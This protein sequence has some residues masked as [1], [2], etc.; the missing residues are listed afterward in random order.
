MNMKYLFNNLLWLAALML[1][2]PA[3]AAQT[4]N[5]TL[6][7]EV[8]TAVEDN[9]EGQ[10]VTL[11]QTDYSVGYGTLKLDREGRCTVKVYPGN[12]RL[13]V[14]R[15][16]YDTAVKDFAVADGETATVTMVLGEK[17]VTPFALK[18][19]VSHDIYTGRDDALLTWNQEA[20]VFTDDFDSYDPWAVNFGA[21]TGIDA[22]GEATAA[23][24]GSYPNRGIMSYAQ[25]V[26]PLT[27][28]PT[29]WY[30][31][32]VLHPYSG[33]QYVGF[34]RTESGRANDDWLIS[35]AITPGTDNV[36]EFMA[37]A[38]DRYT[39][40]F[41]VYVTTVTDNPSTDDF[42]RLDPGNFET[43]D[44]SGW[45]LCSYSLA[46]YAGKEIKFAIRYVSDA[47]RY[48]AFML[49]VDDVY[50]GQARTD[51][52]STMQRAR[53]A[54]RS[55][56]NP[57]EN[58]NLYLDGV[59]AGTTGSYDF[60]FTGIA[61]GHHTLG[62]EATYQQAVSPRTE[63]EID[64]PEGP[65]ARVTFNVEAL[66]KLTA[67]RVEIGLLN[68][69][70]G[71]QETVVTESG[72]R[73]LLSLPYGRYS[74]YVEE[75]VYEAFS[76]ELE[77]SGDAEVDITLSDKIVDPYNLTADFDSETGDVTLRWNRELGFTDSF[78]EYEDFATSS[79]GDWIT[80]D[81]DQA[82]VYPIALGSQTN[83]VTFPGSGT[84]S[85]PTAIA[86]MVFNPWNTVPAMLPTD[87][88]IAA[89]DGD[90]SVIFFS[91]QRT[92]A[93]KWLISPVLEIR[94][95][96]TLTFKAKGYSSMYPESL[97]ICVS[98][99]GSATPA[100]FAAQAVIEQLTSE[101]WGEYTMDLSEWAG[102]SIRIG[103]H[104]VSTDAFLAQVDQFSVGNADGE[105]DFTDPGNV[106]GY[107]IYIDGV[108]AGESAEPRYV[109]TGL[110]PGTHTAGVRTLYLH[111][112]S[113][114]T[115]CTF[116]VEAGI[117]S[118]GA[119]SDDAAPAEIYDLSGRRL[120]GCDAP[121]IY[122]IRRNGQ[123]LKIK[124]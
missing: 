49:M 63:V 118:V 39:E 101:T 26:N 30:D 25:I 43:A 35:P 33:K 59:K 18:A 2:V 87:Q 73:T 85:N 48:G 3:V 51:G 53:R 71:R 96:F 4:R 92:T 28:V 37:K 31:Y 45:K 22:D 102:Q 5:A 61:P 82:P 122:I 78:E 46:D 55:P 114:M 121:G 29:W 60:T 99:D 41:M 21:W 36:L 27:V 13:T 58:F 62:V 110:E 15:A 88:A 1:C 8:T 109:A 120:S 124:K 91:P 44:A 23:L 67:D 66:S 17:T 12:H 19:T 69:D 47:S 111:G 65:Y 40:R 64:V 98:A 56:A 79:F 113:A 54:L 34:I 119:D 50:V 93:N 10:E 116:G 72:T 32:P 16:G 108:K 115:E 24:Q 20:P 105:G 104:Y 80:A 11:E 95:G 76:R 123:T 117:V 83:I 75:G 7:I 106:V 89:P 77:I 74:A 103:L 86:P 57:Y 42:V 97:E 14:E 68:L 107:E 112:Q 9:L 84:A 94:E 70:N 52:Y 90:K 100:D 81:L 6:T 38:A